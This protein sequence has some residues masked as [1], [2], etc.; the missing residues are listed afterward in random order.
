MKDKFFT[1]LNKA[2]CHEHFG[3]EVQLDTLL[4]LTLGGKEWLDSCS[5]HALPLGMSA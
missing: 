5:G 4:T 2:S 1:V 3:V